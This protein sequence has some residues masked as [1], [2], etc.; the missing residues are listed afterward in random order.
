MANQQLSR[1]PMVTPWGKC[2]ERV[3]TLLPD[4]AAHELRKRAAE[5]GAS[6]SELTRTLLLRFLYGDDMVE[7]SLISHYRSMVGK[8]SATAARVGAVRK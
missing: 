1:P 8:S 2:T 7:A 5:A 6:E 3:Q 4:V